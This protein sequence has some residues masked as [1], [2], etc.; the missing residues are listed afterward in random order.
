MILAAQASDPSA[1]QSLA[2]LELSPSAPAEEPSS[3]TYRDIRVSIA[4]MAAEL[5]ASHDLA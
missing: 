3:C 2:L 1:L 5:D 4:L